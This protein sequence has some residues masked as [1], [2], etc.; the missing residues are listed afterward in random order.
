MTA[1]AQR[2]AS[3]IA[4]VSTSGKLIN[5]DNGGTLTDNGD[6]SWSCVV[7]ITPITK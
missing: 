3:S 1:A 7:T 6:G 2:G 4:P 5:I